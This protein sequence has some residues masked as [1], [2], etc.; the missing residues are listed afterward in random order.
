MARAAL[1]SRLVWR[2]EAFSGLVRYYS[3]E[4]LATDGVSPR[5]VEL[6]PGIATGECSTGYCAG[7]SEPC[8]GDEAPFT[9]SVDD[10]DDSDS[11]SD[12]DDHEDDDA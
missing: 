1:G 11:D 10:G 9:C 4:E 5:S 6:Q 2:P 8:S 7:T 12:D 3:G